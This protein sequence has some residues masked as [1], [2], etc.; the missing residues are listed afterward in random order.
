[1]LGS[2]RSVGHVVLAAAM[3]LACS[4]VVLAAAMTLACSGA[5]LAQ[6]YPSRPVT[7]IV[8]FTPGASTD[9]V[10]RLTRDVLARELGQ[11]VVIE[12]RPG[13]GGTLGAGVVASAAPDGYTLLISVNAPLTTNMFT[14]KAYPFEPRTAFA[15]ISLAADSVLV[16]AVN[17]KLPV[18]TVQEL[19]DYVKSNPGKVS[20][21][22]A[23][24]GTAHHIAGEMINRR[25]GID[26]AHVVYRGSAPA[27]Q[28]LVGGNIQVSFG[29][30]PAVLPHAQDGTIRIVALAEAKRHPDMP[31]IPTIGE[32]LPGVVTNTWVGFLAPAGTPR[33]IIDKLNAAMNLALRQP[34]IIE[35][36][37]LQ[38]L[39][40]KG[41]SPDELQELIKTEYGHWEKVIPSIGIQAK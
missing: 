20:Y 19:V 31:G 17:A 24:V 39:T 26:M 1:M 15:P 35:K 14:Q 23:G 10:A 7:I 33:P 22:S 28:D 38:G 30:T 29:T 5:A 21:G 2:V 37:K 6:A 18:K 41:S 12:N 11:P 4:G 9:A 32:T 36:F 27:I 3:T 16:L 13:A 40:A 8:P 25:T 34:D